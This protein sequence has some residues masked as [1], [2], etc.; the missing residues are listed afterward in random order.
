MVSDILKPSLFKHVLLCFVGLF[1]IA[2]VAQAQEPTE[3]LRKVQREFTDTIRP[4]LETQC[5]DCHWG[6][7]ADA[8]LNLEQY[9]TLDQLLSAR[10]KWKKVLIR[11][12]AKEMPPP[13]DY[14]PIPD[15]EHAQL[16][17]WID[18]LL[19]SLIHI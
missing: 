10:K 17:K 1:L 7:N 5:G 16:L 8:D 9:E 11:V 4:I 3:A 12:A 2:A 18:N 13:E 15:D 6:D 14:D 19:L